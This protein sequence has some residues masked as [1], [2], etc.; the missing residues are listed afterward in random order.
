V[1]LQAATLAGSMGWFDAREFGFFVRVILPDLL[2]G[3]SG[4]TG[5]AKAK[6]LFEKAHH[7]TARRDKCR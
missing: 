1:I 5:M 7:G 4:R 2:E 6:E 3:K